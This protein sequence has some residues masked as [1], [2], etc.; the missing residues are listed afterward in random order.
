M[1]ALL[2]TGCVIAELKDE[3]SGAG[4]AHLR[5]LLRLAHRRRPRRAER[6]CAR[7]R[8]RRPPLLIAHLRTAAPAGHR[9][10]SPQVL[11]LMRAAGVPGFRLRGDRRTGAPMPDEVAARRRGRTSTPGSTAY[12]F[13]EADSL[14]LPVK[15]ALL[16]T[17]LRAGPQPRQ[18]RHPEHRRFALR[19]VHHADRRSA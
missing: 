1:N 12:F 6:R 17:T 9:N 7:H 8:R 13:D 14:V 19:R 18:E 4:G 5:H 11:A 16:P 2:R 15:L 10:L 3:G